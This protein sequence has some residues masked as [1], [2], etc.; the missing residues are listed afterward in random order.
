MLI[1]IMLIVIMLIVIMLSAIMLSV[2]M[3]SV[4]A[5]LLYLNALSQTRHMFSDSF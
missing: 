5:P 3:L 1:V 2:I 4:E